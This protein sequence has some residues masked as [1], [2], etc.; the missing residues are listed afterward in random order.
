MRLHLESIGD[1]S[2]NYENEKYVA[3]IGTTTIEE[4]IEKKNHN[5]RMIDITS[6]LSYPKFDEVKD[7]DTTHEI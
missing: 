3:L 7:F 2:L 6:T 4:I 5:I 1:S